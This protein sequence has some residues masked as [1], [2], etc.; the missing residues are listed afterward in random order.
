MFFDA[1]LSADGR[2]S[3]ATCHDPVRAFTDG[4][5][6]ARGI[7][8]QTGTRNTPSLWNVASERS[9]FWDGR[10]TVLETQPLDPLLNPREHGLASESA[11]LD[12]VLSDRGYRSAFAAAFRM[13]V[14]HTEPTH[15]L[16]ALAAFMR[17]LLLEDSPFDRYLYKDDQSALSPAAARGL[18]LFRGTAGCAKC[19]VIERSAAP[20]NDGEF[21]ALGIG[22]DKISAELATL[23][24]T[25]ASTPEAERYSRIGRDFDWAAVGRYA[26]TGDPRDIGKF[27]TPSLRNVALTAP[28]MHDGSV[29]TLEEAI[30][31]EL[32]YRGT[33]RNDPLILTPAEKADLV[34]FLA[35]LTS[36]GATTFRRSSRPAVAP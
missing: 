6:V 12:I 36:P 1:R 26:V 8:G 24:A 5:P 3:C 34:A 11:V 9:L 4:L 35:A 2:T 16:S 18:D 17:T 22:L 13:E 23:A 31:A 32:Y 27:K 33:E 29:A 30:E 19:H 15:V 25:V 10:R 14:A 7:G 20:L 28:Y 21:H